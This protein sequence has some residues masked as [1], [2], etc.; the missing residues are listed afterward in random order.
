[1]NRRFAFV[2]VVLFVAYCVFRFRH[3]SGH[4]PLYEPELVA[5]GSD[6]LLLR[7]YESANG[8][9]YVQEWRC[10]LIAAL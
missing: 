4:P 8:V 10:E 9:G 2:A 5:I 7:G 6:A 3:G 1:M